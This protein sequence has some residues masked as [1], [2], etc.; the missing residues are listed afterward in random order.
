MVVPRARNPG[1][2]ANRPTVFFA[3]P[4][5]KSF[6]KQLP[7]FLGSGYHSTMPTSPRKKDIFD[8][9]RGDREA[10]DHLLARLHDRLQTMAHRE[11]GPALRAKIHT[12]DLLQSAFLDVVR[13]VDAFQGETD[14]QFVGWFKRILHHNIRDKARYFDA[15]KR[16]SGDPE[17]VSNLADVSA[18]T[19]SAEIQM[20][21]FDERMSPEMTLALKNLTKEQREVIELRFTEGLTHNEIAAR[22]GRT[23]ESIRALVWRARSALALELETNRDP[24]KKNIN[25]P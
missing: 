1:A 2:I 17:T 12:S 19:P 10:L 22:V 24:S 4:W 21:D 6:Q 5:Q 9:R 18:Q 13:S 11:L 8:A 7:I 14:E 25:S 20:R 15:Q 23:P 16:R 3:R